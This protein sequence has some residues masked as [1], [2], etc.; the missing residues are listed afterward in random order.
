MSKLEDKAFSRKYGTLYSGLNLSADSENGNR[1]RSALF[2]P[3]VFILR[4]LIFVFFVIM[5]GYFV[6]AQIAVQF[7][8]CTFMI[9]YYGHFW[10]FEEHTLTKLEVFNE[11]IIMGSAYF[12][13][14]YTDWI[15]RA[16][17]RYTMGW[18]FIGLILVH[19]GFHMSLLIHNTFTSCKQKARKN[20]RKSQKSNQNRL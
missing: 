15:P 2:F 6:W 8:C 16:E 1:R 13:L 4:R 19:L 18:Y 11:I 7:A 17:T 3:L 10:P 14:A 20:Y 12:M 5:M 9:I